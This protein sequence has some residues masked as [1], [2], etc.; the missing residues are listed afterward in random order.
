MKVARMLR[1]ARTLQQWQNNLNISN[2]KVELMKIFVV[3][4]FASHWMAC[5]W[6]MIATSDMPG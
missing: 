4:C 2:T 5:I 3:V 6:G 1:A